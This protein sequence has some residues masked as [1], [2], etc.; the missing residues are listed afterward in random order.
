MKIEFSEKIKE[1][2]RK[3]I[4]TIFDEIELQDIKSENDKI[5]IEIIN[6]KFEYPEE[7]QTV[8]DRINEGEKHRILYLSSEINIFQ[9]LT[10]QIRNFSLGYNSEQ[11]ENHPYFIIEDFKRLKE[12]RNLFLTDEEQVK[13]PK[14]KKIIKLHF[15]KKNK[16]LCNSVGGKSQ[17]ITGS[18]LRL[19]ECFLKYPKTFKCKK[20]EVIK[21][22]KGENQHS[23]AR[24]Q[25]LSLLGGIADINSIP[26]KEDKKSVEY[27]QLIAI[28]N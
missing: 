17:K 28:E 26:Y 18:S 2:I 24:R 14:N 19:L 23:G 12:I 9:N 3:V 25:L 22:M 1:K 8:I 13:I 21:K 10:A 27:Y 15:D 7:L 16:K 5:Q 6:K 11:V 20:E 4:E